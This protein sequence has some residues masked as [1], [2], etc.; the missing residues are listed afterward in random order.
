MERNWDSSNINDLSRKF[1]IAAREL[2]EAISRGEDKVTIDEKRE[3][4]TELTIAINRCKNNRH[5]G[6]EDHR[7]Y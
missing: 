4:F 5:R 7:Y 6:D 1:L 2:K 3:L